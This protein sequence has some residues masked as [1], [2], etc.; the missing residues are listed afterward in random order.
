[1]IHP[2]L[3]FN[4]CILIEKYLLFGLSWARQVSKTFQKAVLVICNYDQKNVHFQH[5]LN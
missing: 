3:I 4:I 1:M 5:V 2:A